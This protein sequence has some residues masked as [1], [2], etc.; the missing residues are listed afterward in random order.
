MTVHQI[1]V[2]KCCVCGEKIPRKWVLCRSCFPEYSK[3]FKE[4]WFVELVHNQKSQDYIDTQ[5]RYSLDMPP[6][7]IEVK[8]NNRGG[9]K[10]NI[11]IIR[12]AKHLRSKGI[13]LR[14]IGKSLG[15]SYETIRKILSIP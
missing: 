1:D 4:Q 7:E 12:D 11:D 10:I 2:I 15:L 8:V 13:S 6:P 9:M 5:E 14:N 3:Y